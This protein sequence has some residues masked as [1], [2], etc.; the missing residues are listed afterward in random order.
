MDYDIVYRPDGK[1]VLTHFADASGEQ[2]LC[3]QERSPWPE[4]GADNPPG[5]VPCMMALALEDK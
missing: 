4:I 5:C 3:G 1:L 2:L